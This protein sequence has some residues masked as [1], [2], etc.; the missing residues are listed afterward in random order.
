MKCNRMAAPIT[1][2]ATNRYGKGTKSRSIVGEGVMIVFVLLLLSSVEFV[3]VV[4]VVVLVC[5]VSV[6]FFV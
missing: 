6:S 2:R 1:I 5:E 3:G 4:G